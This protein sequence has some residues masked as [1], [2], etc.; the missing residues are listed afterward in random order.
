MDNKMRGFTLIEVLTVIVII[1]ILCTL[2]FIGGRGMLISSQLNESRDQFLAAIEEAKTRS[3]TGRPHG[4]VIDST[5]VYRLV[6]LTDSGFCSK[7]T[8]TACNCT[9]GCSSPCPGG[10]ICLFGDFRRQGTESLASLYTVTLKS[11]MQIARAN[12]C[13]D[14]ELWFDRRGVPRCSDWSL[15]LSTISFSKEGNTRSITLDRAGRVKYE[16]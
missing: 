9:D 5:S 2:A 14:A 4:I 16:N 11:N 12:A 7:T 3:V 8:T 13:G 15:A 6:R 10:E 1:S